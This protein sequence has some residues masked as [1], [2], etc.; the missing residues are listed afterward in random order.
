MAA[1]NTRTPTKV[2]AR[3]PI[4]RLCGESKESL[5]LIKVFGNAGLSKEISK[6]EE[7]SGRICITE[8]DTRSKVLC[9]TCVSFVNKM[10]ELFIN[11]VQKQQEE[12]EEFS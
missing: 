5:Y 1:E 4:C 3:N 8:N 9:R 10:Y 11:K 2:S 12:F 6:K 7:L